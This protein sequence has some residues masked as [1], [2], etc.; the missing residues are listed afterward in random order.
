MV[1]AHAVSRQVQRPPSAY[2]NTDLPRYPALTH[3]SDAQNRRSGRRFPLFLLFLHRIIS[4]RHIVCHRNP[5]LMTT[6][7][8]KKQQSG[9]VF[10]A[11][12]CCSQQLSKRKVMA[13]TFCPVCEDVR[14]TAL[15]AIIVNLTS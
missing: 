9:P 11:V 13:Y 6:G 1:G 2:R 14:A 3:S 4:A 15:T 7:H 8:I 10:F 5:G 12:S